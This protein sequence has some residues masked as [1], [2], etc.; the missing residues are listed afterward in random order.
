MQGAVEGAPDYVI[1][2]AI[3]RCQGAV[4]GTVQGTRE[5][6]RNQNSMF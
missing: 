3:G 6:K 5:A 4:E 2:F 1:M